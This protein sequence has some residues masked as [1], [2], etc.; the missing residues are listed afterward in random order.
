MKYFTGIKSYEELKS[1]YKELLKKFHPDN[2][3][4]LEVMKDV[5]VEYAALFPI[6]KNRKEAETGNAVDETVQSTKRKFYTECGWEG[7]RYDGNL[8]L[9]EI[10]RS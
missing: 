10:A 8:S 4:D 6:W 3:G 5:N 9:K 7:S 2:G 1:R